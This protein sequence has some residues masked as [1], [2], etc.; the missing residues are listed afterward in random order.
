MKYLSIDIETTG[1]DP[2]VNDILEIGGLYEDSNSMC[3]RQS[4]P[5]FHY[6]IWKENYVGN[7]FALAMNAKILEKI[8]ELRKINS[9][10]L[11]HPH[12][13][14]GKLAEFLNQ[15]Y[16]MQ[17]EKLTLAG[18]NVANFDLRF[19]E[20]LP[21]WGAVPIHRRILDPTPYYID[22]IGDKCPPDMQVCKNRA[23]LP[24]SVTHNALDD[25]WDVVCLLRQKYP[26]A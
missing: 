21:G 9:P 3:S 12:E 13:V 11:I 5:T 24:G 1:L 23:D 10:L 16:W 18:K 17:E 8:I 4:M 22:W 20:R 15:H 6:Y 7:A 14:A 2:M 19:L 25:A 26:N